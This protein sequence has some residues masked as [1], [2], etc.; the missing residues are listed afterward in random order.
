ML[1]PAAS[2]LSHEFPRGEPAEHREDERDHV[3][4][5]GVVRE[6][7]L[8]EHDADGE[9]DECSDD[10]GQEGHFTSEAPNLLT[11]KPALR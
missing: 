6:D 8:R 3:R 1:L 2:P 11:H 7:D 4:P 9:A 10:A 5:V